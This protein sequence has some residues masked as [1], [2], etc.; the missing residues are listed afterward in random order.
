MTL[1]AEAPNHS[2][3][4]ARLGSAPDPL[5]HPGAPGSPGS[6]VRHRLLQRGESAVAYV[7]LALAA[8]LALSVAA[9]VCWTL[10]NERAAVRD[11]RLTEI[12]TVATLLAQSAESLMAA[13]DPSAVRRLVID[14]ARRHE[15]TQCRVLLP[16][17]QILADTAP[18]RV[19]LDRLP[20]AWVGA[21]VDAIR[22][23]AGD[24]AITVS[25]PL[26]VAGRGPATLDLQADIAYPL[27][28]ESQT[29]IGLA[30][31][32]A[33]ALLALLF[34]YRSMRFR[35]RSLGA[36]RESLLAM[37]RGENEE[38]ALRLSPVLGQEAQVWNHLL[39]DR[40]EVRKQSILEKTREA[41]VGRGGADLR[42]ACDVI[43]QGMILVDDSLTV[44]YAN[45][46]A[47]T[48]VQ[49]KRELLVGGPIAAFMKD[50]RVLAALREAS[51]GPSRKR[52]TIELEQQTDEGAGVLRYHV[53]P[54][55]RDDAAAAIILI[56]DVTQQRVA[57]KSRN[58]FVA[59]ATH[60]L[61]TP[62]TN[63]RL[64][65][66]T[67][68]EQGEKDPAER[69]RCLNVINQETAR[70]ERIVDD[71]L[72]IAEI[73]AGS[74]KLTH[75]DVRI[76]ELM[77][78]LLVDY[79]KQ[80][81]DSGIALAFNLPPKLPTLHADRDKLAL[82]MHNLIGNALKYTPRGGRV[83]VNVDA[84][85]NRLVFEVRDTGIG[86]S[87]E[88]QAHVFD[89][90][91]RANDRRVDL[92]VGTGLGLAIARDV[93]RLHGGDITVESELDKGSTF[94]LTVPTNAEAA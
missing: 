61:R 18:K 81:Q 16:D 57:D 12:Q 82:A 37:E 9:G 75:D 78:R 30:A 70:L 73:E 54:V 39:A 59:Q 20:A 7:G 72:K 94:T 77:A 67:A 5:A 66:E 80:A 33:A 11:R 89:K 10:R 6:L 62:L 88:D 4:A 8:I 27:W 71:L 85:E 69:A 74:L 25:H 92:I 43:S 2:T 68:L 14:A 29:S 13:D 35:L 76:D 90:F 40:A 28:L 41:L 56:E 34:V 26:H 65:V 55:R 49:A 21:D 45:G 22:F 44:R 42:G 53:R 64:Y 3:R 50:S 38:S 52:T 19:T 1:E 24:S 51:A 63:I 23:E 93:I 31:I 86:I 60:E 83:A 87:K 17:G 36:I 48:F 15:L 47:A 58:A 46:A 84:D 91:Y 79:E 32:G